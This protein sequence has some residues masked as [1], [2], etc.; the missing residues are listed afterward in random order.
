MLPH[1]STLLLNPLLKLPRPAGLQGG[2]LILEPKL[3]LGCRKKT[4]PFF[5]ISLFRKSFHRFQQRE[6]GEEFLILKLSASA[7]ASR[8]DE[9]LE[10]VCLKAVPEPAVFIWLIIFIIG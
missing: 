5:N 4:K 8:S 2:L 6:G 1:L 3:Q 9:E 10:S 7:G